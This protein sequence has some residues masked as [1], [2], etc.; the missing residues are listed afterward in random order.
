MECQTVQNNEKNCSWN[1]EQ[2]RI[3]RRIVHGMLNSSE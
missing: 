2:F 3:M 1:V